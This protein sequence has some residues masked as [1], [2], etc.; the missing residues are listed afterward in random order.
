MTLP[1]EKSP[2]VARN[3]P[4]FETA[5]VLKDVSPQSKVSKTSNVSIFHRFTKPLLPTEKR[6][7]ES[8]VMSIEVIG[9]SLGK[10]LIREWS[11][12]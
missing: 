12:T 9:S 1:L 4:S 2:P 8:P 7:F 5:K 11:S 6:I 3:L 10:C